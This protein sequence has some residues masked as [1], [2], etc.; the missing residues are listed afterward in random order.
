MNFF[1]QNQSSKE[2]L[3]ASR[4]NTDGC[5]DAIFRIKI[6]KKSVPKGTL[7]LAHRFSAGYLAQIDS[8]P[9]GT[10]RINRPT[11]AGRPRGT[12]APHGRACNLT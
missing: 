12:A 2:S 5:C 9:G 11:Y 4:N 3:T 1:H 7:N 8:S 6:P 10:I